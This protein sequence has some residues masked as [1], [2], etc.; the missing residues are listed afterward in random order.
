MCR[1][2]YAQCVLKIVVPHCPELQVM[3]L[4][5]ETVR[6]GRRVH[7]DACRPTAMAAERSVIPSRRTWSVVVLERCGLLDAGEAVRVCT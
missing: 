1:T 7:V 5:G 3:E 4:S 6:P 2:L